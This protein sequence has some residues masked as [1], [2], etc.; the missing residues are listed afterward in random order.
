MEEQSVQGER[1]AENKVAHSL[2]PIAKRAFC[3]RRGCVRRG[4]S[5]SPAVGARFLWGEPVELSARLAPRLRTRRTSHRHQ[6]ERGEA[7]QGESGASSLDGEFETR[8]ETHTLT[9][10]KL[11]DQSKA[12]AATLVHRW[13]PQLL[14][15]LPN[16][17]S[18][19]PR[20]AF[21][22]RFLDSFP[23][24]LRQVFAKDSSH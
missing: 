20:K 3:E 15:I 9:A 17:P 2:Q 10:P 1:H 21:S 24:S 8:A 11:S 12:T 19:C 4:A 13:D 5:H 18:P 23:S 22:S 7:S 6:R 16:S 14:A